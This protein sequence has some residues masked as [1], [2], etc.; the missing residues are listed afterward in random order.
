[1]R[2]HCLL[3][4]FAASV[5]FA[6]IAPSAPSNPAPAT[7]STAQEVPADA[8]VITLQGLCPD[9]PA[10]TDP[11]SPDCKTIVTRAEF[12]HLADTLSPNMAPSAKQSLASD[13]SRMLVLS[14]E[15]RKHGLEDSQHYKDLVNFLKLQLL[16]QELFRSYQE[17]SKPSPAE[18]E[19][20]YNNNVAKYEEFS[21]KR[22]FI[23]RNR[24]DQAETQ[25][26]GEPTTSLKPRT[27][28]ELQA[29][30]DRIPRA[31]RRRWRLR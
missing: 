26:P 4:C 23:P 8:P 3:F 10:G 30:A 21:L 9:K 24:P 17:Q 25:K 7:T 16:A 1:M 29:E 13:Y 6:Q 28:P 31:T 19:K 2:K 15:A 11:K 14:N 5:S 27:D 20:Y 18:L 12:D 22:L